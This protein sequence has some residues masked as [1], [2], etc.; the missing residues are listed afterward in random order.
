M[1]HIDAWKSRVRRYLVSRNTHDYEALLLRMARVA[2]G[3]PPWE[4]ALAHVGASEL[5][6]AGAYVREFERAA[7]MMVE[8]RVAGQSARPMHVVTSA[9]RGRAPSR[10]VVTDGA[11]SAASLPE[12][13]HAAKARA[14]AKVVHRATL[15]HPP[16]QDAPSFEVEV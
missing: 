16:P 3:R 11:P 13:V 14:P 1:P 5:F 2:R 9:L 4:A 6:D 8:L 15:L 7:R 12:H 10:S